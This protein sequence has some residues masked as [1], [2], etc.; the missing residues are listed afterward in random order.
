[1]SLHG[2]V[3]SAISQ[4]VEQMILQAK[5]DS[6]ARVRHDL[7]VARSQLQHMEGLIADLTERC[8][9]AARAN[10]PGVPDPAQTVDR[11][12]LNQKISQLEQKWGSEVKALKQDLHRTILA[13]NH[14]SD[15]MRHHRDALD[16]ARRKLDAQMQ[17]KAEQVDQQ[18]NKVE[19][20]LRQGQAKQRAI[21]TLTQ[22]LD[23]LE[24]QVGEILPNAAQMGYPG[25]M[26]GM[27]G[28]P[29]MIPPGMGGQRET[30][31]SA[32]RA[33]KKDG[34]EAPTE[35]E[36]KARL[37]Q[38]AK[39]GQAS[40]ADTTTFNAEAPVFVPRGAS[41]GAEGPAS[42]TPMKLGGAGD[43]TADTTG[44]LAEPIKLGGGDLSGAAVTVQGMD[45]DDVAEGLEEADCPQEEVTADAAAADEPAEVGV[46][47]VDEEPA[48]K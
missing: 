22:R 33:S 9:R 38:A 23:A 28:M 42:G 17:P 25:M 36:I 46:P 35:D 39:A 19:Q 2:E 44:D 43:S 21:E 41:A 16:E 37:L 26:P 7:S 29:N 3:A 6:E 48:E 14:N 27:P 8:A 1:M 45:G 15:L 11:S 24:A 4:Q 10:G 30:Q 31:P 5:K 40:S 12:F 47:A 34:G 18:I 13:H 20:M 32:K